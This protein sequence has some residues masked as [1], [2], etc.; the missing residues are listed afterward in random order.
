LLSRIPCPPI[1]RCPRSNGSTAPS[2]AFR[3]P[4]RTGTALSRRAHESGQGGGIRPAPPGGTGSETALS[5][6]R[7]PEKNRPAVGKESGRLPRQRFFHGQLTEIHEALIRCAGGSAILGSKDWS[8][9]TRQAGDL[10]T[11]GFRPK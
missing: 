8:E 2:C 1:T 11:W 5:A 10:R 3:G 6:L 4:S 9:R 7:G